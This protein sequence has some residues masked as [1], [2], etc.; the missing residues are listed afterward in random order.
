[1]T[2]ISGLRG[3]AGAAG[4]TCRRSRATILILALGPL[5]AACGHDDGSRFT[6]QEVAARFAQLTGDRLVVDPAAATHGGAAVLSLSQGQADATIQ[7]TRYGTFSIYVL[8]NDQERSL[9]KLDSRGSAVRPDVRSGIYWQQ[10]SASP[11]S[12]QASKPYR[13]VVL[14]W[15][16]GDARRTDTRW[17][18]LDAVLSSLGHPASQARLTPEDTPCARRG[19]DPDRGTTGTCKLGAQTLTVVNRGQRLTLAG[20]TVTRVQARISRV[21]TSRTLGS[22]A[23]ARGRFVEIAFRVTNHGTS[24]LGDVT[25]TLVVGKRR[26]SVDQR[27][28]FFVQGD[29]PFPI[30][31]G[32]RA[33]VRAVY[34]VPPTIA[35][36][37]RSIGGL[38]V[39]GDSKRT[40][41][42]IDGA[43]TI[44]RV[45]LH[46]R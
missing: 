6:Q 10:L 2:R 17:D 31:S 3:N 8:D 30:Q 16:A 1:M 42:T 12:W 18:R 14:Q 29:N 28:Q 21:L 7:Q 45:R 37:V 15:Q 43:S 19:I 34:D 33:T 40:A 5:L 13:N 32:E 24:E 27:H 41:A 35:R 11:P 23:R 4:R 26:Y 25:P 39:N 9:Y 36:Q 22:R 46:A 44:G 38:V 20:Y